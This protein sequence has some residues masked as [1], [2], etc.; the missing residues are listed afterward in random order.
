MQIASASPEYVR[1]EEIPAEAVEKKRAF[2]REQLEE[3]DRQSGKSRPAEALDKIVE[4]KLNKWFKEVCLLE[5]ESMLREGDKDDIG[6]I[7][8]KLSAKIGEK[9]TIRRFV[10]YE[11]GEG[12]EKKVSNL[13]EEVAEQLKGG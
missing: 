9:L 1:R 8:D 10:R 11:L 12:I 13:A 2:F 6:T 7:L 4:G 3:E 5:Q